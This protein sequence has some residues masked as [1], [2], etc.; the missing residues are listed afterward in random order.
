MFFVRATKLLYEKLKNS[1]RARCCFSKGEFLRDIGQIMWELSGYIFAGLLTQ[2]AINRT[3]K[4]ISSMI[5]MKPH[6][7]CSCP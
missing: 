3:L 5:L 7:I 1:A 6:G 2:P 4:Q